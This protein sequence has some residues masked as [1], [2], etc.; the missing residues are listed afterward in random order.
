M[1]RNIAA[2]CGLLLAWSISC[3]A[4]EETISEAWIRDAFGLDATT[5]ILY[6]SETGEA[7]TFEEFQA[8]VTEGKSFGKPMD[9][10]GPVILKVFEPGP[11]LE[12]PTT[13]PELDLVDLDGRSIRSKDF[14][15]HE[16]LVNFFFAECAPCV[17]ETPALNEFAKLNPQV[18]VLAITFDEANIA[19]QYVLD[20]GF[21][22]PIVGNAQ[23]FIFGAGIYAFPSYVLLDKDGSLLGVQM[24][25]IDKPVI[26]EPT[27]VAHVA[28]LVESLRASA[29]KQ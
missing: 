5:E 8:L 13:F 6:E 20:H 21:E 4:E 12:V 29:P 23:E 10:D 25:G 27:T 19:R 18:A 24:G 1:R 2:V 7:L 26:T 14:L 22:W 17:E 15:G 28:G 11:P 9:T 16:L 3:L